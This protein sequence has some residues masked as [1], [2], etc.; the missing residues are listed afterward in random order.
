MATIDPP[1]A[2][3]DDVAGIWRALRGDEVEMV[4]N[5]LDDASAMIL[6]SPLVVARITAGTLSAGTLRY[7]AKHMVRRVMLNPGGLRQFSTT[8]DDATKSGTYDT[9]VSSGQL[10]ITDG[11]FSRLLGEVPTSAQTGAFTIRPYFEPDLVVYP[12]T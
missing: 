4:D 3:G 2:T 11:E 5:L 1:F 9:T 8:V 6:E 7:V 12:W 10:Y